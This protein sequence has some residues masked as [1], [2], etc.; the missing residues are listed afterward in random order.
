MPHTYLLDSKNSNNKSRY[1][2]IMLY[3][4]RWD[5]KGFYGILSQKKKFLDSLP[6]WGRNVC[7]RLVSCHKLPDVR[8]PLFTVVKFP[9]ICINRCWVLGGQGWQTGP[10]EIRSWEGG[11]CPLKV[12]K[13]RNDFCKPMFPPKNERTNSTSRQLV[14]VHFLEEI[15]GTKKTF[16]N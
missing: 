4:N 10:V 2:L 13:S 5:R 9:S 7:S 12:K 15:E 16:R 3:V 14:F 1:P 11:T 8:T 6:Y